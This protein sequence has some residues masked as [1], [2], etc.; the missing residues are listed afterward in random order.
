MLLLRLAT[1]PGVSLATH[2]PGSAEMPR[3]ARGEVPLAGD[4]SARR[5]FR[6]PIACGAL[7]HR[8]LYSRPDDFEQVEGVSAAAIANASTQSATAWRRMDADVEMAKSAATPHPS[9]G[10]GL[11]MSQ[12]E[13]GEQAEVIWRASISSHYFL[14]PFQAVNG[15]ILGLAFMSVKHDTLDRNISITSLKDA[16]SNFGRFIMDE[17][18]G[19][20]FITHFREDNTMFIAWTKSLY[21]C[22]R[23][24][25]LVLYKVPQVNGTPPTQVLLRNSF[26]QRRDCPMCSTVDANSIN[27][28]S[29]PCCGMTVHHDR[30]SG[31]NNSWRGFNAFD[32]RFNGRYWGIV[33]KRQYDGDTRMNTISEHLPMLMDVR[34]G[35]AY[36]S[37]RIKEA[38]QNSTIPVYFGIG[39]RSSTRVFLVNTVVTQAALNY[40]TAH[41]PECEGTNVRAHSASVSPTISFSSPYH[42]FHLIDG[43]A[44]AATYPIVLAPA[45]NK[46]SR[47]NESYA[48]S[49]HT[50]HRVRNVDTQLDEH[51]TREH[52]RKLRNRLSAA[53]SNVRRKMKQEMACEQLRQLKE[54]AS[55]LSTRKAALENENS[56]L[57]Q[58]YSVPQNAFTH[59]ITMPS[60]ITLDDPFGGHDMMSGH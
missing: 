31:E 10:V 19:E 5:I 8:W 43:L 40:V 32:R 48:N 24:R 28:L 25:E 36:L 9:D 18:T 59:P 39:P 15:I 50:V 60:L 4:R 45:S 16:A 44:S 57:K 41:S 49:G 6:L 7:A 38:F 26:Y 22:E 51:E 54:R 12:G 53:N 46:I 52:Q 17:T 13:V 47:V 11:D 30:G 58:Q 27:A 14:V 33:E 34:N 23:V 37:R 35:T 2:N 42:R 3:W 29:P 20:V 55:M 56:E 21:S 1:E